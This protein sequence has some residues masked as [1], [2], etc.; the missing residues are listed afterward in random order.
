L[1]WIRNLSRSKRTR[2]LRYRQLPH[3]LAV[4]DATGIAVDA[5]ALAAA[6][7]I[8]IAVETEVVAE[9]EAA[10]EVVVEIAAATVVETEVLA[11]SEPK[12]PTTATATRLRQVRHALTKT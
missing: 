9:I 2:L 12:L 5:A 3:A 10:T 7:E 8:V 11:Q 6:D 4:V 1:D